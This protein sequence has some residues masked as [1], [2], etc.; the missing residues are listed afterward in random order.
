VKYAASVRRLHCGEQA[1]PECQSLKQIEWAALQPFMQRYPRYVGTYDVEAIPFLADLDRAVQAWFLQIANDL[2]VVFP[3]RSGA[4]GKLRSRHPAY[5]HSVAGD[6]VCAEKDVFRA[7]LPERFRDAI[8]IADGS[9]PER[10]DRRRCRG[11]GFRV[12]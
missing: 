10:R 8:S 7:I 2:D 1:T 9:S 11:G 12:G 3:M 6:Y 4:H 5:H